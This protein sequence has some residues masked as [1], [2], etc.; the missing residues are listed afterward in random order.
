MRSAFDE[1][2]QRPPSP[3][4]RST[5]RRR[6]ALVTAL[7]VLALTLF[8]IAYELD[9]AARGGVERVIASRAAEGHPHRTPEKCFD[10]DPETDFVTEAAD[11]EAFVGLVYSRAVRVLRVRHRPGRVNPPY[12]ILGAALEWSDDGESWLAASG[13]VASETGLLDIQPDETGAHRFWRL[14]ILRSGPSPLTVVGEIELTTARESASQRR[15]RLLVLAASVLLA[16][17]AVTALWR[18]ADA[19]RSLGERLRR[20]LRHLNQSGYP[21]WITAAGFA[22]YYYYVYLWKFAVLPTVFDDTASYIEKSIWRPPGYY[23]WLELLDLLGVDWTALPAVQL[24]LLLA[25]VVLIAYAVARISHSTLAGIAVLA[26]VS[27]NEFYF[28]YPSWVL[29][30]SLFSAFMVCHVA[31]VLLLLVRNSLRTAL[32][33]GIA[34]ML[35]A[36]LKSVGLVLAVPAALSLIFVKSRRR[37][38]ALLLLVPVIAFQLVASGSNAVRHGVFGTSALGGPALLGHVGWALQ[39]RPGGPYPE[40]VARIEK[41]TAPLL[42]E[43]PEHFKS[44]LAYAA[45]T[46]AEY[47]RLLWGKIWPEIMAEVDDG[48]LPV[49]AAW[50]R[51]SRIARDLALDTVRRQPARYARHVVAHYW[52]MWRVLLPAKLLSR[53]LT[54]A[55]R[56][57]ALLLEH[58]EPGTPLALAASLWRAR[59]P[60]AAASRGL[61]P[62]SFESRWLSPTAPVAVT[63]RVAGGSL[64]E[65]AVGSADAAKVLLLVSLLGCLAALAASRLSPV[66]A[67]WSVTSLYTNAYMGGHALFQVYLVR[68]AAVVQPLAWSSAVLAAV[69]LLR[70]A[71]RWLGRRRARPERERERRARNA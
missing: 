24:T 62:A 59:V 30:E 18:G 70:L 44:L 26:L 17:A 56:R 43:R 48:S 60:A 29:T 4:E 14:S 23:L 8:T 38:A 64:G 32:G 55:S 31:L 3:G 41:R 28:L 6:R 12:R 10:R 71:S 11:G 47:N 15:A 7:V 16:L 21:L 45:Y 13:I 34:L 1:P 35:A 2:R 27:Q 49:P 65:I 67:A 66:A 57:L 5:L 61:D 25:S 36:S 33:A 52:G 20:F 19:G 68:Y 42:A 39:S 53:E 40:L 54:E 58:P 37:R 46:S 9:S 22:G 51:G 50:V 69:L 63:R